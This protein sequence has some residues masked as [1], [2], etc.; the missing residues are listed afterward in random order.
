MCAGPC[1]HRPSACADSR[2]DT[3][4]TFQRATAMFFRRASDILSR[5]LSLPTRVALRGSATFTSSLLSGAKR[6][7]YEYDF[8]LPSLRRTCKHVEWSIIISAQAA[9]IFGVSC[10]PVSAEASSVDESISEKDKGDALI[11]GLRRVEDGSVGKLDEAEKYFLLA[12]KEAKEGF[13]ERDP[14]VAS[15]LNNLAELYR[16]QK[17]FEKAEPLYLDA[18][19]ILEEAFGPEDV[20]YGNLWNDEDETEIEGGGHPTGFLFCIPSETVFAPQQ[21]TAKRAPHRVVGPIGHRWDIPPGVRPWWGV[22]PGARPR[23]DIPP[24]ARPR[25]GVPPG[26]GYR[27][28]HRAGPM[29][30]PTGLQVLVGLPTDSRDPMG[31]PTGSLTPVEAPTGP[32]GPGG[33]PAARRTPLLTIILTQGYLVQIKGRVLGYAHTDYADTMY[34]L[35]T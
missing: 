14:H 23:W 12:L 10:C 9:F 7:S 24:G 1:Q 17:A 11:S 8:G 3:D 22:P 28:D 33:A 13:G 18:I 20:R 19:N 30:L 26:A 16:V 25:W 31:L 2:T 5:I 6:C 15:S 32:Q 27:W 29:G 4:D 34:H 35:G 21:G